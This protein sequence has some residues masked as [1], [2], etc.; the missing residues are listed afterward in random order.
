MERTAIFIDGSNFYS[1]LRSCNIKID[2]VKFL[3]YFKDRYQL[4]RASYYTALS[5]NAEYNPIKP[6]V[7]FLDYNGYSVIKKN[8]K[9]FIDP[10]TGNRRF[11]GNM[12][13][14][15][16]VDMMEISDRIDHIIL[17]SGDGDFRRV[18]EAIQRK[19]VRVTVL[20]T[21][22]SE[23][24]ILADELRRQADEFIDLMSIQEYISADNT[25]RHYDDDDD[26]AE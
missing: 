23:Q 3:K 5:D 26:N 7:D 25:K 4:V 22:E 14:D 21:I 17:V 24:T 13:L 6:L 11:K 8:M 1:T 9:E 10:V 15:M 20:S 19:G 16:T 12:D 2:Y 18:L